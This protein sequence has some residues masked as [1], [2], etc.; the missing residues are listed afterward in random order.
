MAGNGTPL[1][2]GHLNGNGNGHVAA[3]G[4][5]SA[6]KAML[7]EEFEVAAPNV[8]YTAEHITAKYAYNTTEV[9]KASGADGAPVWKAKPVSTTYE[10]R[11]ER[12][13]PKLGCV[14]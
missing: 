5:N 6:L 11:T 2:N 4:C 12:K 14:R 13:V 7:V 10:F 9:F 3:G 1:T 8:A